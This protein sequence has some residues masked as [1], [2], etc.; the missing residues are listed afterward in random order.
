MVEIAENRLVEQF[1]VFNKI[2]VNL[3]LQTAALGASVGLISDLQGSPR[4]GPESARYPSFHCERE[5]TLSGHHGNPG[6]AF[7]WSV[8]L[9][10]REARGGVDRRPRRGRFS[11][12]GERRL[13]VSPAE[14]DR[15]VPHDDFV[16]AWPLIPRYISQDT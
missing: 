11:I 14:S 5:I 9:G 16:F 2:D 3:P 13:G 10:S 12:L 7:T 4:E 1:V 6:W 8:S 15:R